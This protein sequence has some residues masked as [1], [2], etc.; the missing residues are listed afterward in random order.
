MG[1]AQP[2]SSVRFAPLS[3]DFTE[4][5]DGYRHSFAD[6]RAQMIGAKMI[7][8]DAGQVEFAQAILDRRV[9][10][11]MSTSDVE[12]MGVL[13]GDQIVRQ[14][15][16]QWL[17]VTDQSGIYPVVCHKRKTAFASPLSMVLK[18]FRRGEVDFNFEDLV[19]S[20]I[21]TCL[22]QIAHAQDLPPDLRR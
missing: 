11:P 3:K 6:L 12:A 18:R 8:A 16:F 22:Q 14:G 21:Q 5:L 2:V 7:K 13:F 10:S 9:L 20:T 15:D 17:S 1:A 19:K 4:I